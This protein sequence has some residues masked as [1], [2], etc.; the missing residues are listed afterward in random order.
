MVI[1]L[2]YLFVA[3]LIY[4]TNVTIK[5]EPQKSSLI[6]EDLFSGQVSSSRPEISTEVELI[7]SRTNIGKGCK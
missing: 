7:K 3:T 5:I 1:T 4:E 2:A 6:Y